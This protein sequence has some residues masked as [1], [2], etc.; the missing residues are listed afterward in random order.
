MVP[1]GAHDGEV[2][3]LDL[4]CHRRRTCRLGAGLARG[5]YAI[6]GKAAGEIGGLVL[7]GLSRVFRQTDGD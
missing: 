1:A 6:A 5:R 3:C 2:A 7:A 4:R